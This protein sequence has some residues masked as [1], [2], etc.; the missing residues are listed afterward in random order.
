M[1]F[2]LSF[3]WIFFFLLA[4]Y[5]NVVKIYLMIFLLMFIHEMGHV[6]IAKLL[7]HKV[8]DI[9][10]YPFGFS[11]TI[12]HLNHMNPIDVVLILIGGIG[13]HFLFPIL[14]KILYDFEYIS[15]VYYQYMIQI[16]HSI[17]IFNLLP[18]FPLD[19][20]RF[21]FSLLRFFL[22]YRFS[23]H[24]TL[25]ISVFCIIVLFIYSK[26]SMKIILIFISYLIFIEIVREDEDYVDYQ[27]YQ[28]IVSK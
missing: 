21:L 27:Y 7:N 23:K 24:I 1:K 15:Y 20:G 19:G 13:F 3:F 2:H 12:Q 4:I 26:H 5:S 22:S 28:R 25:F 11:A 6:V 18:I 10:V 14:F 8:K 16:N 9:H 17:L